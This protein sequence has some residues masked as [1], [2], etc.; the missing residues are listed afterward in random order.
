MQPI[1]ETIQ[2]QLPS[3]SLQKVKPAASPDK[4]TPN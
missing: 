2:E 3:D 1:P 4:A